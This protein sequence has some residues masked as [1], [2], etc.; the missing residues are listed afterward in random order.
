LLGIGAVVVDND[1]CAADHSAG[2]VKHR[3]ANRT[4]G[5]GLRQAK[6]CRKT[7]NKKD[8]KFPHLDPPHQ[9]GHAIRPTCLVAVKFQLKI[10]IAGKTREFY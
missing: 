5:C 10:V 1:F 3:A 8:N 6:R 7:E 9:M 2:F 4:I